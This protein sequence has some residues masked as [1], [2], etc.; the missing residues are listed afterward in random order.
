MA[1]AAQGLADPRPTGRVDRRHLRKVFARI[2][3]IQID[4]VNVLVRSQELP[5]FARLGPHPR[6]LLPDALD[7]G[8]LFEYWAHMAAIVPSAHHPLFRWRMASHHHWR[9]VERLGARTVRRSS[10]RSSSASRRRPADAAD[11][12]QRVGP[13]GPWWDWD[14]GKIALEYLFCR[15]RVRRAAG[16]AATS[17]ASTTCPS[18][19]CRPP[20]WTAPTPTEAEAAQGAARRWPARAL[21]VATL[22]DLADYHRQGTR[23]CRPL[24]AEL[25]EEGRLRPAAVE[26]WKPPG[27]R[28]PRRHVP[29]RVDGPGAA[30]PVRLAGLEPRPHRAAV[31]LPLPHRDLHRRRRSG[32]TATTCCRSCSTASSSGAS[33]SRPTAP[34]AS[35]ACRAPSPSPASRV[36]GSG[37]AGRGA[38]LDGRLARARRRRHDASAASS[39]PAL[40]R[41][42]MAAARRSTTVVARRRRRGAYA[43]GWPASPSAAAR[44]RRAGRP[45]RLPT[46][47]VVDG[48]PEEADPTRRRRRARR[49]PRWVVPGR[50][51]VL[52]RLPGRRSSCASSGAS[53]TGSSSCWPSRSSSRWPSSR[54]STAWPAGA[55][56]GARR[57][58]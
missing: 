56:G 43:P 8:E 11:L 54:A 29:R 10:T 53:S 51:R 57:R 47:P 21:G 6:N 16:A 35:C 42:G 15:G 58:R 30:Q 49:L 40:R 7:D 12:E 4:S 14:D 1:V 2:G 34:P 19:C 37:R 48:D 38:A 18:G 24:V 32:S 25:V 28:A 27:L 26:G 22:E 23:P 50:R 17:P 31:R 45:S 52:G 13:K 3:V 5:L 33:T 41:A 46:V 39:R 55:G 9:A 44:P 20:C 36:D